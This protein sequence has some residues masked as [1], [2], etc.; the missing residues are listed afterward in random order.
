MER[1]FTHTVE[2][3]LDMVDVCGGHFLPMGHKCGVL[4]SP[5]R[6]APRLLTYTSLDAEAIR[7]PL[8]C[9][10]PGSPCLAAAGI[11]SLH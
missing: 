9:V 3:P 2:R 8:Q 1:L 7:N 4:E 5:R 6:A 11:F 10:T